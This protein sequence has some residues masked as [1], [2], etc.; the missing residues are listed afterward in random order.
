MSKKQLKNKDYPFFAILDLDPNGGW[1]GK[2]GDH[3][4]ARAFLKSSLEVHPDRSLG[5]P[6]MEWRQAFQAYQVLST[7][8]GREEYLEAG[9]E[10][11]MDQHRLH[12]EL[13]EL[14][15]WRAVH[16]EIVKDVVEYLVWDVGEGH[17]PERA[18]RDRLGV[19]SKGKWTGYLPAVWRHDDVLPLLEHEDRGDW[20]VRVI[21]NAVLASR[22]D[23]ELE[24]LRQVR[25][26]IQF[27]ARSWM[28]RGLQSGLSLQ[29]LGGN[30]VAL[31]VPS[32]RE[33]ATGLAEVP[34]F[35]LVVAADWWLATRAMK[36]ETRTPG[37][38]VIRA[39]H[40]L[41]TQARGPIQPGKAK[42][43]DLPI[44][45]SPAHL[46][47]HGPST[48]REAQAIHAG[49]N[50]PRF[51]ALMAQAGIEPTFF[52]PPR[53]ADAKAGDAQQ[54]EMFSTTD[55]ARRDGVLAGEVAELLR[56]AQAEHGDRYRGLH[57]PEAIRFAEELVDVA[58]ARP[59]SP[60]ERRALMNQRST[61]SA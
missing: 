23:Y 43:E 58:A 9:H 24:H 19:I 1:S 41:L 8:T 20:D 46:A 55:G 2:T 38:E 16:L 50:T 3:A 10:G 18:L 35:K 57:L 37:V 45:T 30:E 56:A 53:D 51:H 60:G 15:D 27:K 34:H 52:A 33:K 21:L 4:V 11:W 5:R 28:T 42:V 31:W 40:K 7:E 47:L 48:T 17:S 26:A 25:V 59:L 54:D 14:R 61:V 49:C 22:R 6:D 29:A 36:D 13:P 12:A 44:Q 39:L 32:A